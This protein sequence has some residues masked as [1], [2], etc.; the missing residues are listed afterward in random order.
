MSNIDVALLVIIGV[1]A[2][3]GLGWLVKEM[4]S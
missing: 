3:I 2:V 1:V 4:N